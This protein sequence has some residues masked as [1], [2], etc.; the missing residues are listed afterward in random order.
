MRGGLVQ[1]RSARSEVIN[2]MQDLSKRLPM[3]VWLVALS[4]LTSRICHPHVETQ[5]ITQHILTRVT[6]QFPHQVRSIVALLQD[7]ADCESRFCATGHTFAYAVLLI[8]MQAWCA[9]YR[10]LTHLCDTP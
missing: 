8:C 2:V 1:E 6:A 7:C 3:Y 9:S 10:L 5:R 4:Q